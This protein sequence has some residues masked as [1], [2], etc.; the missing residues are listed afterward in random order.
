METIKI[1]EKLTRAIIENVTR[2]MIEDAKKRINKELDDSFEEIV[3]SVMIEVEM[4]KDVI[5]RSDHFHIHL[6]K[7]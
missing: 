6:N 3:A 1:I 7:K 5:S 4:R 2:Q